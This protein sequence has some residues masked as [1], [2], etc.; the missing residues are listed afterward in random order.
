MPTLPSGRT[1]GLASTIN[2]AQ[3]VWREQTHLFNRADLERV[4]RPQDL[5][6]GIAVVERTADGRDQ[7][8]GV[9][10]GEL[11]DGKGDVC[12]T[13]RAAY[14][15]WLTLPHVV[16]R[17]QQDLD[18]L[19]EALAQIDFRLPANIR[20]LFPEKHATGALLDLAMGAVGTGDSDAVA[21]TS[22]DQ[23]P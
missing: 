13:D 14:A 18:Q 10:I 9:T 16:A 7:P 12:A 23:D 5:Y 3:L 20:E 8:I 17:L 4:R 15:E 1:L 2:Y 6:P 22:P 11:L 19:H 21:D